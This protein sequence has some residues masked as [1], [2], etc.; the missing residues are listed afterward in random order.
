MKYDSHGTGSEGNGIQG[1]LIFILFFL[2]NNHCRSF[3]TVRLQVYF[4]TQMTRILFPHRHTGL[5]IPGLEV[6]GVIRQSHVE[7][8][9]S[10]SQQGDTKRGNDEPFFDM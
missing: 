5:R 4:C 6:P 9:R 7:K 2:Q 10:H 1:N 3:Q 8:Q